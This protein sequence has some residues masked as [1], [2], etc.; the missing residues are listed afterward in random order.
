MVI[1]LASATSLGRA[2]ISTLTSPCSLQLLAALPSELASKASS[3]PSEQGALTESRNGEARMKSCLS[4][5]TPSLPL[6]ETG[7]DEVR[8]SSLSSSCLLARASSLSNSGVSFL[9]STL[10]LLLP[11]SM[12]FSKSASLLSI[13]AGWGSSAS[14]SEEL[15]LE[16]SSSVAGT[17]RVSSDATAMFSSAQAATVSSSSLASASSSA[18]LL[19]ASC[20]KAFVS[21][22][23]A[24]SSFKH[25]TSIF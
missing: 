9:E 4:A 7:L 23:I 12:D 11:P 8:V 13:P 6:S 19:F 5:S 16:E 25:L 21:R 22:S 3:T 15:S 14:S 10:M 20:V 17:D 2:C 24:T 1:A 18:I